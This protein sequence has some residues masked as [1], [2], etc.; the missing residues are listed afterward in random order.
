MVFKLIIVPII[1]RWYFKKHL[2]ITKQ[3]RILWYWYRNYAFRSKK[4]I[5]RLYRAAGWKL[6]I[7]VP[8]I[9]AG[10]HFANNGRQSEL[11]LLCKVNRKECLE[12]LV[13]DWEMRFNGAL[14]IVCFRLVTS[15][16]G[17]WVMLLVCARS[18]R[19]EQSIAYENNK[20]VVWLRC[21]WLRII[22]LKCLL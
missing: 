14:T 8:F 3:N 1:T 9:G 4:R 18:R 21:R 6:A 22:L 20:I 12:Q 11:K 2:I 19:S 10:F 17:T 16:I 15:C 7:I 5:L 13:K